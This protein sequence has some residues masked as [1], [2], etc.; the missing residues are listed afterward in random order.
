MNQEVWQKGIQDSIGQKAFFQENIQNYQWDERVN[1]F[2]V[3]VLDINQLDA[4]RNKLRGQAISQ[5]LIEG[6]NAD[7]KT[8]APLAYQ[9]ETGLIEYKKHPILSQANITE[10]YQEIEANGHLHLVL[11]G[12][13]IPAGP[14]K[15]NET[16]GLVIKDYQEQLDESL[17]AELR[18]KYPIE[19]NQKAK[20]EAF[21]SLNQ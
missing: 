11:L 1:A 9:T 16:R 3:K 12:E 20:E 4:A 14:K 17:I 21:V 5:E 15:F 6:F 10:S 8:N 2:I 18:E 13:T 19:I 7:F